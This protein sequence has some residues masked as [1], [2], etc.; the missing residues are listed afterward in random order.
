[1][2]AV[3]CGHTAKIE[4][5]RATVSPAIYS[6]AFSLKRLLNWSC[7]V[8][9][10]NSGTGFQALAETQESPVQG[11][12]GVPLKVA[13]PLAHFT[14]LCAVS[15]LRTWTVLEL[16]GPGLAPGFVCAL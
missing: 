8:F 7:L 10:P 15:Q 5:R 9:D 11:M 2:A 13:T 14:T 12:P 16:P 3:T 1:M 6:A 4:Q